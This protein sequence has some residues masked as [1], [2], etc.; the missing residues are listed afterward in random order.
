M[1]TGIDLSGQV[2]TMLL[3]DSRERP[4][5]PAVTWQDRSAETETEWLRENIAPDVGPQHYGENRIG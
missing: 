4:L 2:P 3:L 5:T 1:I